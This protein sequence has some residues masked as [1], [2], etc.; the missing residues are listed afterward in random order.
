MLRHEKGVRKKTMFSYS[1]LWL[2]I[3]FLIFL[4]WSSTLTSGGPSSEHGLGTQHN[5]I[6]IDEST[7]EKFHFN[8]T[9]IG[10]LRSNE[11][12]HHV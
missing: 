10:L 6:S 7:S 3:N 1:Y 11:Q 5:P 8:E 12:Y 2:L 4:E 9:M